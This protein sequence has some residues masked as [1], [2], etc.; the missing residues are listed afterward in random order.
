ML[1]NIFIAVLLIGLL[2]DVKSR[3]GS[4]PPTV[5]IGKHLP[6][7]ITP[8]SI[9]GVRKREIY[10]IPG[11]E[12]AD[13]ENQACEEASCDQECPGRDRKIEGAPKAIGLL[14]PSENNR[15]SC[16]RLDYTDSIIGSLPSF[17]FRNDPKCFTRA[18]SM[19]RFSKRNSQFTLAVWLKQ[20]PRNAG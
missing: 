19:P 4:Y 3:V 15:G 9:C 14:S 11:K 8:E 10:C 13:L 1:K 2:R 17:V 20:V 6:V 12:K 7:T 16:V 18:P 5:N